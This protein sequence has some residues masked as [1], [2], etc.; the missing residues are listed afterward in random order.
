MNNLDDTID[1][2]IKQ[3]LVQLSWLLFRGP[4]NLSQPIEGLQPIQDDK[5]D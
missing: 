1:D 4:Y 2:N 5:H 3:A